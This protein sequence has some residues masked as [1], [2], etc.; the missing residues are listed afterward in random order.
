VLL[1]KWRES[2]CEN[3][4]TFWNSGTFTGNRHGILSQREISLSCGCKLDLAGG[5]M[6]MSKIETT[7]LGATWGAT[8]E[9][10][11]APDFL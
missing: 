3:V 2:D 1:G 10:K 7:G 8:R 4:S 6:I 5:A 9:G 11:I